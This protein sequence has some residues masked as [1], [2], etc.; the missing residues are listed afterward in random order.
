[1]QQTG[2]SGYGNPKGRASELVVEDVRNGYVSI[3][4]AEEK[5]G[6]VIRKGNLDEKATKSKRKNLI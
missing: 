5:Y 4:A 1:M 2:G 6:V 3:A